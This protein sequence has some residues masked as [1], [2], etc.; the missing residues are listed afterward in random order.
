M[1]FLTR[2]AGAAALG[3]AMVIG[4]SLSVPPAQAG[5]IV[6]LTQQGA[7]VVASGSGSIDLADLSADSTGFAS[8]EIDPA[9]PT[10]SI[11]TGPASSTAAA[12]YT[13]Y[14]GPMS[15]GSGRTTTANSGD[16]D[17]VGILVSIDI[18]GGLDADLAVPQS[19][20]SGNPLSDT[21][22]YD[23]A[24]FASLGVTPGT[25]VWTWGAGAHA[26]SFT[27]QIGPAAV[28]VLGVG[29]AGLALAGLWRR[30]HRT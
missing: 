3:V 18:F 24:T 22:T 7:S 15:F 10:G 1:K 9:F 20:V 8:A 28:S 2:I 26:D 6:T 14:S 23:N 25:Y 29:L 30:R 19:Y 27:L 16:G 12:F 21:S 5:Y 17:L 4:S 13:G 11:I